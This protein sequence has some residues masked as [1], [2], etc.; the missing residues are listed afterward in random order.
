MLIMEKYASFV[1]TIKVLWR[2]YMK[3]HQLNYL[4]V[5]LFSSSV[6]N[7]YATPITHLALDVIKAA[8]VKCSKDCSYNCGSNGPYWCAGLSHT[9]SIGSSATRKGN[10]WIF[11]CICTC[12]QFGNICNNT[13]VI[14]KRKELWELDFSHSSSYR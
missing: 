8:K 3:F 1:S 14:I 6:V 11:N 12:Y 10:S 5:L 7:I 13:K 2:F 9:M 4:F